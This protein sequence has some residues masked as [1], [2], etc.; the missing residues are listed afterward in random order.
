MSSEDTKCCCRHDDARQCFLVR[1]PVAGRDYDP[2]YD[3]AIDEACECSCH[4]QDMDEY[5]DSLDMTGE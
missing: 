4:D 1:H 3:S 5:F 2:I